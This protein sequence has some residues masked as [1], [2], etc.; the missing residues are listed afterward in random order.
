MS[1]IIDR[2][3]NQIGDHEIID[4][5]LSLSQ[6]DLNSLLLEIF[7]KQTEKFTPANML[8][9]YR[10]NR[11]SV[12]SKVNPAKFHALEARLLSIAQEMNIQTVLLSPS[13][14]LGSCSVFGCV[15]Q[16]NVVS[17]LRGT[18]TL[19]DPSN[20]LAIIIADKLR[21]KTVTN[22]SPLHYSTTARVIR[23][24]PVE[25]KGFFS[26]FGIYCMVSSCKD[27]GSYTS[28]KKLLEKHLTF[29]KEI[30]QTQ[31]GA[32]VSIILR[33]RGGYKDID[34]FFGKMTETI[35]TIF[36]ETSL[37]FDFENVDNK[38]YQGI[39]FKIMLETKDGQIEIGD[40]G[41]V[42]WISQILGNKKERCLIS[43]IGL[44][45]LLLFNE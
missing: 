13:A 35:E 38:Y 1:V 25:G 4:K 8:K 29:Y 45:R 15:N 28:E 18:E 42:D 26:H 11:F 30:L 39:N 22:T 19:S 37:S 24:Q 43:G 41:F 32:K 12:P 2:I 14:P 17:A 44:D 27:N 36:P 33:K 9:A 23:A 6:A 10:L 5:L 20:M 34:G 7:E 21:N 40:G 16:Y 3:L 31:F